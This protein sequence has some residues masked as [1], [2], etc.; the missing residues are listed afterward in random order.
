MPGFDPRTPPDPPLSAVE[1]EALWDT[2]ASR[3]VI[4]SELVQ[5]LGLMPVGTTV[6]NHAGGKGTS[7]TYIVNFTLPNN[8]HV[9]GSLVTEFPHMK[10][11]FR[12][13]VGMD[14]ICLGDFAV[15][16]AGGHSCMSFRTPSIKAIDYVLEANKIAWANVGRNQPCPCGRKNDKG[17]PVLFK[18]C[19]KP[20]LE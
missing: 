11:G 16:H 3:S 15:T 2:G 10:G 9:A 5:E 20:L 17:E 12:A 18:F 4:S 6:V 19:H 7:N 1:T 14:I 8:V 13:I